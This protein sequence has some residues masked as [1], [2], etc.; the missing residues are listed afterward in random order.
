[1][2]LI[3]RYYAPWGRSFN[4]YLGSTCSTP[5]TEHV[6]SPTAWVSTWHTTAIC[7]GSPETPGLLLA[8]ADHPLG[9]GHLFTLLP[10]HLLFILF[11]H[12]SKPSE[13]S[14]SLSPS[15]SP[16]LSFLLHACL[17]GR[18]MAPWWPQDYGFPVPI[19]G[20]HTES[21]ISKWISNWI[22]W[23]KSEILL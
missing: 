4:K 7:Q 5:S 15:L 14:A 12:I 13:Y 19:S 2:I 11:W 3:L 21:V 6:M 16:Q 20:L 10:P 8:F 18:T 9:T 23:K 1:M 17:Q 22:C